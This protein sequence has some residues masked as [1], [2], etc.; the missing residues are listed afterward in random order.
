MVNHFPDF[1]FFCQKVKIEGE[2]LATIY[3]NCDLNEN[4]LKKFSYLRNKIEKFGYDFEK[5]ILLN[6]HQFK[7]SSLSNRMIIDLN[8]DTQFI[9]DFL[10]KQNKKIHFSVEQNSVVFWSN[11]MK[12]NSIK[13]GIAVLFKRKRK[14]IKSLEID[15]QDS[16]SYPV[17]DSHIEIKISDGIIIEEFYEEDEKSEKTHKDFLTNTISILFKFPLTK[18]SCEAVATFEN[19]FDS[20][21]YA[22]YA[23]KQFPEQLV[24]YDDQANP[25]KF[26]I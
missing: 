1:I 26:S 23:K 17:I 15:H 11:Q 16:F 24:E 13:K 6:K 10:A 2:K 14:T 21:S 4:W 8:Q 5:R 19:I 9:E 3:Y 22:Q 7:I 25:M 18:S 12:I 20:Q